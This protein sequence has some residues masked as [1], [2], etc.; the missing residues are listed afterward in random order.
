M[1]KKLPVIIFLAILIPSDIS[2]GPNHGPVI[3]TFF[4]PYGS[5]SFTVPYVKGN[6]CYTSD[7]SVRDSD[8]FVSLRGYSVSCG[9]FYD[10]FQFDFSYTGMET[11]NLYVVNDSTPGDEQYSDASLWNADIKGGYRF[12]NPG[13]TSYK[14]FYLGIRKMNM[15][16]QYNRTKSDTLGF[17]AGFYGFLSAGF[18]NPVEVV[19]TYDIYAGTCRR[20]Q[21]HLSTDLNIDVDRK[22]AVDLGLSAGIGL[23][24]EP[25]DVAVI[26]KVSSFVTEKK[27]CGMY[28]GNSAETMSALSG[29]VLGIEIVLSIPDYKN[30][31]IE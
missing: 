17:F 1:K 3:K 20:D 26:L 28:Q 11:E 24:Y 8:Q 21:N 6:N 2:A 25:W 31:I 30:N 14:W 18:Y 19:F 15:E 5:G 13:D 23:Q 29:A 22:Y 7:S 9:Y 27:Y 10:W 12:S 16:I 4:A